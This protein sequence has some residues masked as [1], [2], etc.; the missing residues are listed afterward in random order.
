VVRSRSKT[1]V[2]CDAGPLIH[3]H[4]IG[5][6]NLMADFEKVIVPSG[7]QKEVVRHRDVTFAEEDIRW[8]L[9]RPDLPLEYS[10]NAICTLF[11]LDA[12]EVEALSISIKQ[13]NSLFLTDD[14]AARI[15]AGKLGCMVHGTIG[16]VVRSIRRGLLSPE[17]V[18]GVLHKI[19]EKSSLHIKES[20]LQEVIL[21][22]RQEYGV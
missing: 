22:V 12:G 21:T 10:V 17:E 1:A 2:V 18:I 16:I 14:A 5:Y 15:V 20:L 13:P 6:L 3:L 8:L 11:S 7:V 9:V 4:E 19:R